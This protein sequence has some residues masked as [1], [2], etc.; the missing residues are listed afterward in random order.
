MIIVVKFCDQPPLQLCIHNTVVGQKYFDLVQQNY[1]QSIPVYR[2]LTKYTKEYL[3]ELAS[4]AR[5]AFGWNWDQ[6]I[7]FESGIAAQLHKDL[8]LLLVNGFAHIPEQYDNLVHELHYCLHLNQ[9]PSKHTHASWLQIEWYNDQ[10]F[11]L[12]PEFE[13][14]NMLKFGDVKLQN[15]FV[16]HGPWQLWCEQDFSNITQTC[17][18]HTWVKPGINIANRDFPSVKNID[19]IIQAFE[20]HSPEFVQLH[21]I[22]KIKHYTGYPVIGQVLN[23]QDLE[24]VVQQH[25]LVFDSLEFI[26]G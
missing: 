15:P 12:A 2:N 6:I 8:E 18:F 16:G 1:S 13:F 14:R 24:T 23:L 19:E 17:K 9:F 22:N 10:G 26:N 21:G 25:N 7:N 11:E 20:Q 3:L 5:D 4:Q